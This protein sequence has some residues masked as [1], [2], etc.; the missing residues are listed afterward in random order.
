LPSAAPRITSVRAA[1]RNQ[2]SATG[3]SPQPWPGKPAPS[4]G[5]GT[6]RTPTPKFRIGEGLAVLGE[7]PDAPGEIWHLPND[8][9][10][11]TTQKLVD[12]IYRR[13][14]QPRTRIRTVPPL[15][16][17]VLP[18]ISPVV[19]EL[20]ECSTSSK[21]PSSLTAAKS[22]R[23]SES[24][25]RPWS[26]PSQKPSIVT[27]PPVSPTRSEHDHKTQHHEAHG[28]QDSGRA[29]RNWKHRHSDRPFRGC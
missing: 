8:P 17:R 16:L 19:R 27:P 25:R 5:I 29:Q 26:K 2:T 13:A 12:T 7:H 28:G 22:P 15:L 23:G 6:S 9:H 10:T 18:L 21:N 3:S 20:L 14:G 24:Q 11:R 4:W 1:E